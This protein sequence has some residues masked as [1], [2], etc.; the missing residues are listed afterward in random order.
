MEDIGGK[1]KTL[2]DKIKKGLTAAVKVTTAAVAAGSAAVGALTKL[3]VSAYADYEQ[4]VGGVDTLFKSASDKV[5]QYAANAYKTAGLSANAYMETVTSFSA[6]LLQSLGNDTEAAADKADM[7]ITDMSDNANKMGTDMASIQNAYQGFAKQNYTMLDNLKLGYGGTKEEMQRLLDDANKLNAAQGK[8]TRYSIDS[9]ADIVDAIHVVQTEMGITG[10]TALEAS[11]TIQGSIASAKAAWKNLLV[12]IADSNQDFDGL[13]NNF[14]ESVDTAADNVLPRVETALGGIGTLIEKMVPKIVERVPELINNVVP[15]LV[16]SGAS[17]VGAIVD[18]ATQSIPKLIID[19]VPGLLTETLPK[20]IDKASKA[21]NTTLPKLVKSGTSIAKAVLEGIIKAVPTVAKGVTNLVT[22]FLTDVLP[23]LVGEVSEFASI[24]VGEIPKVLT[25]VLSSIPEMVGGLLTSIPEAL[26]SIAGELVTMQA[27]MSGLGLEL[28]NLVA[29][30]RSLKEAAAELTPELGFMD[31]M[32]N[33]NGDTFASLDTKV[34]EAASSITNVLSEAFAKNGELVEEDINKIR[35]YAA[36]LDLL[37]QQEN[38]FYNR[39]IEVEVEKTRAEGISGFEDAA[40]EIQDLHSAFEMTTK[41]IEDNYTAEMDAAV[42]FRA[43]GGSLEDYNNMVAV[44]TETRNKGLED[45]N[46]RLAEGNQLIFDLTKDVLNVNTDVFDKITERMNQYN[47][48][49]KKMLEENADAWWDWNN[50]EMANVSNDIAGY[51]GDITEADAAGL[52]SILQLA[53]DVVATG[54]EL[55][56]GTRAMIDGI[57]AA[58]EALPQES[59]SYGRDM[60][61]GLADGLDDPDGLLDKS[62]KQSCTELLDNMRTVLGIHSPSTVTAEMGKNMVLGLKKGIEDNWSIV[63]NFFLGKIQGLVS[64]ANALLG[65]QSP[66]KVFAEIGR[67]MAAGLGVGWTREFDAVERDITGS[68]GRVSQADSMMAQHTS[69]MVGGIV[70]GIS[71]L[72]GETGG[73][74]NINLVCDGETLAKV[75]FDPMMD[76]ADANGTPL[77]AY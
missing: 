38:E 46:A 71:A 60:I 72:S 29:G 33:A 5:Q 27:P 9:Y 37:I 44:A 14:V 66:S 53:E 10:T 26:K 17:I 6:S 40:Q 7:A 43:A 74:Y 73:T 56:E 57:F 8:Y 69:S 77:M 45:A 23:G 36:E 64:K 49:S 1:A 65:I 15:K 34:S 59:E 3:A 16:K 32:V 39:A 28:Y 67:Y 42:A 11:T 55:D 22:S 12:G 31:S 30:T 58:F 24:L 20:L 35:E 52:S 68:L 48:D 75:T 2:G 54:G 41:A 18:G 4:L 19:T 70:N 76:Y 13:V 47:A 50:G 63:E 51:L 21:L 61:A 62:S 25:T